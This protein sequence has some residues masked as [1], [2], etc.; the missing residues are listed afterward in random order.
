M[1]EPVA[2]PEISVVIPAYLGA[3]TIADCLRS[4]K[5]ALAGRTHEIIVVESSGDSTGEIVRTQFPDV[6]LI[7]SA[8]RLSAGA[9]RN[10]G[11]A[12]A[13]A[14][15]LFLTDQDCIVPPD[16]IRRLEDHLK[17]PTVSAV[18]GAVGIRDLSNLSGCAVYFLEFLR[19]FPSSGMARRNGNFLVGCNSAYRTDA[20]L[21][22][23]F[24]DQTLGED[25]L[26]SDDLRRNGLTIVYDPRVAVSHHNRTGWGEF[27]D[28][29]RKMGTAA[30][31]YQV[32]LKPWWVQPFLRMPSLTFL[33]PGII[34]PSIGLALIRG[35]WSYISRF[36]LLLPMCFLG[37]L[38]WAA[39]F[40]RK[41]IELRSDNDQR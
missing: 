8:A 29:N 35:R 31:A 26:F 24:P 36:L 6:K 4:L 37:N 27:F 14:P 17:D 23:P 28:Y 16:W 34:L 11:A 13:R 25:V 39:A 15:L 7:L 5:L 21:R 32:A 9:A 40:R 20:V 10:R 1:E 12:E 22:I 18:G 2:V 41:V 33:A 38:A 19:H 30:A 3:S